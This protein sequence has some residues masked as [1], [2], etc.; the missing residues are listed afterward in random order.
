MLL[1][2]PCGGPDHSHILVS[3]S[4]VGN[5]CCDLAPSFLFLS[6]LAS[7]QCFSSASPQAGSGSFPGSQG[8]WDEETQ[9]QKGSCCTSRR[10]LEGSAARSHP[11]PLTLTLKVCMSRRS[12]WHL[13]TTQLCVLWAWHCNLK[14]QVS[15][16]SVGPMKAKARNLRV[17]GYRAW[18]ITLPCL[19]LSQPQFLSSVSDSFSPV[20]FIVLKEA[21]PSVCP[22]IYSVHLFLSSRIPLFSCVRELLSLKCPQSAYLNRFHSLPER[23]IASTKFFLLPDWHLQ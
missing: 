19:L 12:E 1:L 6:P 21:P 11:E 7:P 22:F 15:G 14:D 18:G 20:T 17:R 16:L 23:L 3:L 5:L 13:G 9:C 2:V 10:G 8:G 4:Q